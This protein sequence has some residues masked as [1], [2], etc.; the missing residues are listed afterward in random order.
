MTSAEKIISGII[1]EAEDEAAG[2]ISSAEMTAR[3]IIAKAKKETELQVEKIAKDTEKRAALIRNTGKSGAALIVRDAVL[4][5][6]RGEIERVLGEAVERINSMPDRE[7]FTFLA[8]IAEKS[9]CK[10]EI[11]LSKRDS[12][13][14]ISLFKEALADTGIALSEGYVDINGGF[15][16]KCGNIE[17]TA[18]PSALVRDRM[19]EL[20][21][22]V[23]DILFK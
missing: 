20:V 10:G 1:G 2:I 9:G 8:S 14:D 12:R 5:T 6:K 16:L 23:N 22:C 11:Y 18:E 3:E 13:R 21:D 15:I 4:S 19:S 7:Y 17:I